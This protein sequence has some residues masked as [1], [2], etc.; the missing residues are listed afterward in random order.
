MAFLTLTQVESWLG[1]AVL[2]TGFSASD[3]L[4][5][6][7]AAIDWAIEDAWPEFAW[8]TFQDLILD[9]VTTRFALTGADIRPARLPDQNQPLAPNTARVAAPATVPPITQS[10]TVTTAAAGTYTA[11]TQYHTAYGDTS[12][13]APGTLV[14]AALKSIT[15]PAI[16]VPTTG[17]AITSVKDYLSKG[18]NDPILWLA[19]TRS[20]VAG[21]AAAA[22][23]NPTALSGSTDM[24]Q[25]YAAGFTEQSWSVARRSLDVEHQTNTAGAYTDDS[26]VVSLTDAGTAGTNVRL[27]YWR[28]AP[29]VTNGSDIIYLDPTYLRDAALV[30]YL[31][32]LA[33]SS[34][35]GDS[36]TY[37]KR[38]DDLRVRLEAKRAT[39]GRAM[40]DDGLDDRGLF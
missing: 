10:N 19:G 7:K 17:I 28:R 6:Q 36:D 9:G 32:V 35:S 22:T 29:A 40:P 12:F 25:T 20:V 1:N 39:I 27:W 5:A 38:A 23:Y 30:R 15:F 13:S 24:P 11:C 16:T 21:V 4:L 26:S 33:M 2:T 3:K 31:D 8:L 14:L 37:T 34:P 18:A